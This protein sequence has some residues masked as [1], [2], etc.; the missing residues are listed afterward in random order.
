ML[1]LK[2]ILNA[3]TAGLTIFISVIVV[4]A[5]LLRLRMGQRNQKW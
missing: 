4:F 3:F 5:A 2:Q 1:L